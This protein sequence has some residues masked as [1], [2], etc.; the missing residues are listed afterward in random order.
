MAS[1][2]TTTG[3][4]QRRRVI[5][6][7]RLLALLDESKAPI[8]TLVAPAGYGK[9][10][11][12]EQW[13]QLEGRG[14]AWYTAR[15]SS[16]DVAALALGLARASTALVSD[17]DERLREH[18]RAL[19]GSTAKVDVLAEILAEDLADWPRN[20]WLVV[21]DYQEIAASEEAERFVGALVAA[22]PVQLLIASR[23]RP[24]WITARRIL[25]DEVLELNQ[26]TLAMDT[27]EASQVL[28]GRDLPSAAG[29]VAVANGWPAVIGLAGVS[30]AEI[31]DSEQ[32]PESLYRFF[33]EEVFASLDDEVKAGLA[34][35]AIAPV[36]DRELATVLLGQDRAEVV[37]TGALDVGILV[38]RGALLELHPLA[39]SF[40]EDRCAQLGFVPGTDSVAIAVDHYRGRGDWDAAFDVIARNRLGS[41]LEELVVEALDDLLATARLQTIEAWCELGASLGLQS[42]AFPLAR[43][44]VA[45]RRG[46]LTEAQAHAEAAAE[47][48]SELRFRALHVAGRAAHIASREEEALELYRRAEAAAPSGIERR[49]ALW[50]QLMCGIELELPETL[51]NMQ[52]LAAGVSRTDPRGVVRS[53]T[54]AMSYGTRFGLT[55]LADAHAAYELLPTVEDPLVVSSFQA[56]YGWVLQLTAR[57][58]S[59]IQVAQELL[60]TTTR[61]RLDF[62]VPYALATLA[63]SSA[64]LRSWR[65]AGAFAA[66]ALAIS[67]KARDVAAEQHAFSVYMRVLTQQRHHHKA[68]ELEMPSLRRAVPGAHA[69]VVLC[70]ALALA[71]AGRVKEARELAHK[72]R[73]SSRA[74]LPSVLAVAVQAVS[75]VNQGESDVVERTLELEEVAFA[76]GAVDLLVTTYRSTPALLPLLL[77]AT[78]ERERLGRL[79]KRVGDQELAVAAGH[80]IPDDH[81]PI[82]RLSV[83]EREVYELL[84]QGLTNLQIAQLLF[85][86]EGTVK[87][88]VHHI[89]DKVGIRSRT[90]LAVRA[91]LDRADQATSAIDDETSDGD[92]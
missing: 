62:A 86:S 80:R 69:E 32:L 55:D 90:A 21:D 5:Q 4:R 23:L 84:A 18:L 37:C 52:A 1:T 15:R 33:A 39:R 58:D 6:R 36:L 12:A 48:E 49:E 71:S 75:S 19:S 78:R 2:A 46:R 34:T 56:V 89:F 26:T 17:C 7:P 51:E 42:P 43:A 3:V 9:T 30:N 8:R 10:T 72:T 83:R 20:G 73:I 74:I 59:S 81:D 91:A 88:H 60:D 27:T 64:G 38:E 41:E 29:L 44:E 66:Q 22:A 40:L 68:L 13:V 87:V 16:T 82:A 47:D 53:A 57:Y 35:L 85:I 67:R 50:G 45:L 61:Y 54:Y 25:Y 24:C 77:R 92:S 11:L 31:A 65:Q 14:S 79:L 63:A 76:T 70:R 28:A